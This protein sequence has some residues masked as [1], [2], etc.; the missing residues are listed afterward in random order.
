MD[1]KTLL[2]KIEEAIEIKR[3]FFVENAERLIEAAELI[4]E[5]FRK[6]GKLL[7]VGNGGSAADAQ[8]LAAEFVNRFE[9]ER[10]PLPA[11]ALTTDTSILTSV[12]NDYSFHEVFSKQVRAL[13]RAGDMLLAIS[14]SGNSENVL[15]ALE[16]SKKMDIATIALTGKDGGRL[17]GMAD[18]TLVVEAESTPRIQEVHITACHILCELT[19]KMLFE[20]QNR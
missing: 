6:G 14:T 17:K 13:G 4:A 10:A 5:V 9:M 11:I 18:I 8:H 3:R 2:N 15:K 12:G 16:Q 1:S 19:E 7:I 20:G